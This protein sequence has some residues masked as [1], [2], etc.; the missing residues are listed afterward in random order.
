MIYIIIFDVRFWSTFA[1]I[2]RKDFS[3]LTLSSCSY[4]I[5]YC[6]LQQAIPWYLYNFI[7]C[8]YQLSD[9]CTI[10]ER[11]M[12]G[13]DANLYIRERVHLH[14]QHQQ[15]RPRFIDRQKERERERDKYRYSEKESEQPK[16]REKV[17]ERLKQR[18]RL[19]KELNVETERNK[20][21]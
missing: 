14:T 3:W 19:K 18:L 4:F 5:I 9:R 17:K 8:I 1:F 2:H 16:K 20:R 13:T 6:S 21:E 15:V 12:L 7:Y 10:A 11:T